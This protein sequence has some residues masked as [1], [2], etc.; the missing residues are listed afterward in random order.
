MWQLCGAYAVCGFTTAIISAHFVAYVVERGFSP[1]TAATA[2]GLMSGLN[3][4]GVVSAGF[5]GDRFR[6]K[7]LLGLV[8]ATRGC[9]YAALLLAPDQWGLWAFAVIAGLSWLATVP[10]TTALTADVYG[11]KHLGL[12]SG[13][14]F[15]AHQL[16][17]SIGIQFGGIMRDLTGS[18]DWPF[19]VAALLLAGASLASFAIQEKKYS[20][21]YQVALPSPTP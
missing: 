8:Y 19:T 12:L 17:G 14:T 20:A 2:F 21:R 16:G 7:N 4:L 10:L 18:Y 5:M 6:R 1:T 15:T 9:G 11:L 3:I 13:L